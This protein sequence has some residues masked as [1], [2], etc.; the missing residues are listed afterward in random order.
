MSEFADLFSYELSSPV[1][2]VLMIGSISA[3]L[4]LIV[5]AL[6]TARRSLAMSHSVHGGSMRL[7]SP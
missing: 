4:I 1:C 5:L 7:S 6:W 3:M 2:R